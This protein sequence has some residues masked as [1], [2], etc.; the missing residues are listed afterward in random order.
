M[1]GL[2]Y[3]KKTSTASDNDYHWK[4]ISQGWED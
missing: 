1:K 4:S 3:R 2:E